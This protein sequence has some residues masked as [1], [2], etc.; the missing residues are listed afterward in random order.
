MRKIIHVDM[1]C[2]YAAV[3]TKY[4]PEYKG[5][6]LGVGGPANSRGVLTTANYEARKYGL[7]SAMP[8]SRA[9]RL[10]PDLILVPPNMQLYKTE[11]GKVRKILERYTDRIQPLSLDEAYLD[12]TNSEQ[13]GGSASKI[14]FQIR[15]SIYEELQLTASAGI[16][17]NK[18][19]AK[20]ASDWNKPNGQLTVQPSEI[21]KFMPPLPVEKLFGVG[22]VTANYL[23]EQGV[24]TCGDL[25]KLDPAELKRL[26]GKRAMEM[27]EQCRGIDHRDVRSDW[28]RKSLSVEETYDK[29]LHSYA[30]IETKLP[31][32][33]EDFERRMS[34]GNYWQ[35]IRG[36]VVK[37]KFTDF[38]QTTHETSSTSPPMI[39]DF[40][41][42]LRETFDKTG[43]S[44]RLLGIGVRLARDQISHNEDKQMLL[45]S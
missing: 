22:K 29:D 40:S 32:L 41:R 31:A 27:F 5:K 4:H 45:W 25:Q 13:F 14:A 24:K 44:V 8:S 26:F 35:S 43:D 6:P 37:L 34:K 16:A 42:L 2:F 36:W 33:Y 23:H 15:K 10:C 28:I 11:S 17:P 18:L 7:R 30:E 3:E 1:D 20:I 19:V 9:A 39:S 12:V 38:R 21:E